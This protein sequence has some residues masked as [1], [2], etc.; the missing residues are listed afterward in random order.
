M[1]AVAVVGARPGL[2]GVRQQHLLLPSEG[3]AAVEVGGVLL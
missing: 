2:G 1:H 3:L